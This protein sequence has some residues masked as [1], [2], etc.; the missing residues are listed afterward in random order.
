MDRSE[1]DEKIYFNRRGVIKR[2][3]GISLAGLIMVG[4]APEAYTAGQ[5]SQPTYG[6]LIEPKIKGYANG[7]TYDLAIDLRF[8]EHKTGIRLSGGTG[9]YAESVSLGEGCIS[10]KICGDADGIDSRITE[11]NAEYLMPE[12][13]MEI[14]DSETKALIAQG[15][16]VDIFLENDT[17]R[18]AEVYFIVREYP[19]K[20]G[21]QCSAD[22]YADNTGK[23]LTRVTV[24]RRIKERF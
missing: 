5:K 1:K 12:L 9:S 19:N 10:R 13:M 20:E 4:L 11:E 18:E 22:H 15:S 16:G 2:I 17:G 24:G 8:R 3:A 14:R 6:C 21:E 7:R 23:F